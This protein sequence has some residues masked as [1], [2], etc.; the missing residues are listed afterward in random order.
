[1]SVFLRIALLNLFNNVIK[2]SRSKTNPLVEFGS[3]NDPY[4]AQT[5]YV[6][7]NGVGF[8][9]QYAGRLFGAF[10][11]LYAL[12]ECERMSIG[13]ATVVRIIHCHHDVIRGRGG[14][15]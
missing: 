13:L 6:R 11:R 3:F 12:S 10:Q 1:M 7:D 4:T 5:I 8:D 9:M 14:S 15:C 2:C